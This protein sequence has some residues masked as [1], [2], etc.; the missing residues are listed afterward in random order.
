MTIRRRGGGDWGGRISYRHAFDS[1]TPTGSSSVAESFDPRAHFFDP[2]RREY[3]QRISKTE[4]KI[5]MVEAMLV[6]GIVTL[7]FDASAVTL[8]KG[9]GGE[10]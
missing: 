8:A 5:E 10:A 6:T 2:V 9:G 7:E 1:P 4:G 3:A